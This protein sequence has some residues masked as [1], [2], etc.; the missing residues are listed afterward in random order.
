[1]KEVRQ[2]RKDLDYQGKAWRDEFWSIFKNLRENGGRLEKEGLTGEA[3]AY[4]CAAK[5]MKD[6]TINTTMEDELI[7]ERE[8]CARI[9]EKWHEEYCPIE[10]SVD[11]TRRNC[12]CSARMIGAAIRAHQPS[13]ESPLT[14]DVR[15]LTS[16]KSYLIE[17]LEKFRNRDGCFC[18]AL[19]ESR[20]VGVGPPG[21]SPNCEA[22]R[23]AIGR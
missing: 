8:A 5:L 23:C 3:N 12:E 10:F 7:A 4:Y 6:Q 20:V 21:H 11:P 13:R 14:E 2:L 19:R 16:S 1:V 15:R 18:N 22:I 17:L 9:A